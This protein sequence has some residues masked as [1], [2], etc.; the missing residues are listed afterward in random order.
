[1]LRVF[2]RSQHFPMLRRA[3]NVINRTKI[4]SDGFQLPVCYYSAKRPSFISRVV[5]NFKQELEKNKEMS[6]NIKKFREEANKLEHSDALKSARQKFN[7]VESEASKSG[8]ALKETLGSFKEKVEKVLDEAGKT[9]IAKKASQI[10]ED[11]SKTAQNVGESIAE[12]G[13]MIG[14]TGAF[15][16]ISD[17]VKNDLENQGLHGRV[18]RSPLKL[19]KRVEVAATT[20]DRSFEPNAEALGI[21]LHK[22]SKFYQQWENFKN[23]NEYVNKVLD[24]KI[25]YEE[26]DNPMIRGTRFFTDKISSVFGGMFSKT[27]LSETLTEICKIDPSFDQKQFLR[28]C[29]NDIIPNIL[30]A[31]V[32]GNVDI[33]KDWC[34]ESTYNVIAT[35]IVQAQKL[36][37][38]LDSK[39]LDIE[40]VDIAMGKVMDQGPVLIITFQ[41]QQIMCVRDSKKAVVEGSPDKVMRVNYVWVLCRDPEELNPKAAWRLM[42]I[43]ANSTEQFV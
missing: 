36:G 34:F 9:D 20:D 11:I 23:N 7:T 42:D 18:Y 21:E 25:K 5:D 41:S 37:Y 3:V 32:R 1:M 35:P 19:R 30:E 13:S 40:N 12:K 14:K 16:T 17:V 39:I 28:D 8:E 38:Y 43:S 27:E 29:E 15:Q 22:D 6:E 10:G 33:L 24:W 4:V 2:K 26:S 31:M